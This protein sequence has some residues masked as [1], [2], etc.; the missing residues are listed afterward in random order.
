MSGKL[1]FSENP[2]SESRT[3]F[4]GVS[5]FVCTGNLHVYGR[6]RLQY[7]VQHVYRLVR[8]NCEF[9]D[10]WYNEKNVFN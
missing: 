7:R 6:L 2:L 3:L 4:K 5:E 10:G 8:S 1:G 9:A